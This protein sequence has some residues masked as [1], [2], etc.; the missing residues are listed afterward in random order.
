MDKEYICNLYHHE[1]ECCPYE[2]E[3]KDE[4]GNIVVGCSYE[5]EITWPLDCKHWGNCIYSICPCDKW[6]KGEK[7]ELVLL[8]MERLRQ[9]LKMASVDIS[10][11]MKC[12]PDEYL[13]DLGT[14]DYY[15]EVKDE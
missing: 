15:E 8:E 4:E 10:K 6:E 9:M 7:D 11:L 13:H 12:K 3:Q 5:R 2:S 1:C 14:R